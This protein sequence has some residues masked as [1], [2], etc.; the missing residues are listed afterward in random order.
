MEEIHNVVPIA[1]GY[2]ALQV[3]Q[4]N[5]KGEEL[6]LTMLVDNQGPLV[7]SLYNT[8]TE[9]LLNWRYITLDHPISITDEEL[10]SVLGLLDSQGYIPRG[11]EV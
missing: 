9:E 3:L 4:V 11:E 6:V 8:V 7:M 10:E 2:V 5:A 1:P